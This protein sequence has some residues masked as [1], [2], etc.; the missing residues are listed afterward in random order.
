MALI[1]YATVGEFAY[2]FFE[3]EDGKSPVVC[4]LNSSIHWIENILQVKPQKDIYSN[5]T[6]YLTDEQLTL[7]ILKFG[8]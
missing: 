6:Y 3:K 4:L 5:F 8:K 2:Y 7:F 1:D